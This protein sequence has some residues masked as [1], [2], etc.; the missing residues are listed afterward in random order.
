L[1]VERSKCAEYCDDE[2]TNPAEKP[3]DRKTPDGAWVFVPP[4]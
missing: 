3:A 4:P 2:S 1:V